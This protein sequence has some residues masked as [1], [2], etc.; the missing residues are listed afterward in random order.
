MPKRIIKSK[1]DFNRG[2]H[3]GFAAGKRQVLLSMQFIEF[4]EKKNMT[5]EEFA[6]GANVPEWFI[7][8]IEDIDYFVFL[9]SDIGHYFNVAKFCD[10]AVDISY[11]SMGDNNITTQ[12]VKV[13]TF[14]EEFGNNS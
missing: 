14:E 5:I 4:R 3:H 12:N 6:K 7:K 9:K 11:T 2:F 1:R 13:K 8:G 10:V